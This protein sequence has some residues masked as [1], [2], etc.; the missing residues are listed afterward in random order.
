MVDLTVQEELCSAAAMQVAV[1]ASGGVCG[2]TKR[3]QKGIEASL[4]MVRG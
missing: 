2:I 1:D 3:R 4:A